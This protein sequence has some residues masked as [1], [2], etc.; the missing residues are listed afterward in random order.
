MKIEMMNK[1]NIKIDIVSDVVCPWCY[2]GKRRLE[3]ALEQLNH[4]YNFE[5]EY[6]PFELNPDMPASGV[7]QREYLTEKF[8]GEDRYD[9]ITSH[10]STVAAEEGLAFNFTNQPVSPNTRSMHVVLTLAKQEG[11]QLQVMEAFF[12]AYFSDAVDLSKKE[13]ILTIAAQAGL[14]RTK[15]EQ[16]LADDNTTVQVALAEKEMYKLGISGVPFFIL[17]N[18]YGVSGAQST[19]TFLKALEDIGAEVATAESC[20]VNGKNC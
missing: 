6:H 14:D 9:Q 18:K 2:I 13:N 8:G 4:K 20:D 10:T 12:K 15:A 17:N 3:K 5:L 11:V 16:Y 1:P 19:E 7:N